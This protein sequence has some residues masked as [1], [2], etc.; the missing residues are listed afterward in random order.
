MH[1]PRALRRGARLGLVALALLLAGCGPIDRPPAKRFFVVFHN[2]AVF[3]QKV[4]VRSAIAGVYVGG[5]VERKVPA[6]GELAFA[7]EAQQPDLVDVEA[8]WGR[9]AWS[10]PEVEGTW[11]L[12]VSFPDGASWKGYP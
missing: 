9:V 4:T 11:V 2:R 7:L 3:E 12:H 5:A 1:A 8:G 6:G 10:G